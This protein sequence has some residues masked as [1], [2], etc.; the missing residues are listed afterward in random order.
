MV[1]PTRR[2][3]LA[4]A[5]GKTSPAWFALYW[6]HSCRRAMSESWPCAL[7]G[8]NEHPPVGYG[9]VGLNI[10]TH[11]VWSHFQCFMWCQIYISASLLVTSALVELGLFGPM[12]GD[13]GWS[14]FCRG[15]CLL[16]KTSG[17]ASSKKSHAVGRATRSALDSLSDVR[18]FQGCSTTNSAGTTPLLKVSSHQNGSHSLS[19]EGFWTVCAINSPHSLE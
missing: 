12:A 18:A 5:S 11:R 2:S 3:R 19:T 6:D 7:I 9:P 16:Y 14:C 4:V 10:V 13:H 15:W 17:V 1:R 8:Y